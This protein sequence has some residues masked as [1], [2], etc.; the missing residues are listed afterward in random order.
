[1]LKIFFFIVA[2]LL[3]ATNLAG[4]TDPGPVAA[5]GATGGAAKAP[6]RIVGD[7][8][9]RFQAL[10]KNPDFL[11]EAN[12]LYAS[13]IHYVQGDDW[14]RLA[15]P[16]WR[17]NYLTF[18]AAWAERALH[19]IVPEVAPSGRFAAY[20][21]RHFERALRRGFGICSQ[22]AV[23]LSD[24]LTVRYGIDTQIVALDGHVV[25]QARTPRGNYVLLDPS[26][27]ISFDF[28]AAAAPSRLDR[29]HAAYSAVDPGLAHLARTYDAGGNRITAGRHGARDDWPSMYLA[30][31]VLGWMKWAVPAILLVVALFLPSRAR[32]TA[33]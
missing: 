26:T 21:Y 11:V 29:I 2:I 6:G 5:P 33:G 16:S 32:R 28:D 25:L 9:A 8:D 13:A 14:K 17:D 3:I 20:E 23:G 19:A 1:V 24:L 18:L 12:R 4:L 27:G 30:E 10:G 15:H 22:N 31:T 7:I